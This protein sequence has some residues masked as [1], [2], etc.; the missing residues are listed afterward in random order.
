M[1]L[2]LWQCGG[3]PNSHHYPLQ[4]SSGSQPSQSSLSVSVCK[5]WVIGQSGRELHLPCLYFLCLTFSHHLENKPSHTHINSH[6]E[7]AMQAAR[8]RI[9][10]CLLNSWWNE[11]L[12]MRRTCEYLTALFVNYRLSDTWRVPQIMIFLGAYVPHLWPQHYS[13][14][15][16]TQVLTGHWRATGRKLPTAEAPGSEKC[17]LQDFHPVKSACTGSGTFP[18]CFNSNCLVL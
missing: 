9:S 15:L 7:Q 6:N 18:S 12:N 4:Q 8:R 3:S 11:G 16:P 5:S 2:F 13:V 17:R 10:T 1:S 14:H